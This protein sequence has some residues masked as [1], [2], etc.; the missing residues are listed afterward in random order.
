V[1]LA[2]DGN[3]EGRGPIVG[4]PLNELAIGPSAGAWGR[5][6]G[7]HGRIAYFTT[8]GGTAQPP[9]RKYRTAKLLRVDVS[10]IP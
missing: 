7:D 2:P 4:D 10:A 8:D 6:P 5:A 9:D 3:R 1:H